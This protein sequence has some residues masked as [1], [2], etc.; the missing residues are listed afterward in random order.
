VVHNLFPIGSEYLFV[1][2]APAA[3][4]TDR[5]SAASGYRTKDEFTVLAFGGSYA[6]AI[7]GD[8]L[9]RVAASGQYA[10]NAL[11]AGE[12]L[13]VAGS[14]A[15]RGFLERAVAVDRGYFANFEAYSPD[16]AASAGLPGNLKWLV[17]LMPPGASISTRRSMRRSISLR[18]VLAC[19]TT[20]RRT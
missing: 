6:T 13:G 1:P 3:G 17:F 9:L 4:G 7:G 14:N 15:V 16:I 5:Y 10:E 2:V 8:W 18:W 11:P 19:A 20:S 12:R